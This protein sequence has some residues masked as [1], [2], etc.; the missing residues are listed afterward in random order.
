MRVKVSVPQELIAGTL[1]QAAHD[2]GI[3]DEQAHAGA[4]LQPMQARWLL[5][6]AA[7]VAS[8]ARAGRPAIAVRVA[9][10]VCFDEAQLAQAIRRQLP[11]AR[12]RD[13]A[14]ETAIAVAAHG[15]AVEVT[16]TRRGRGS[17]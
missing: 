16:V 12:V 15:S 8:E 13:H 9:D 3:G 7:L 4:P 14:Q 11:S 5:P 6:I 2:D 1:A 17:E 10:G